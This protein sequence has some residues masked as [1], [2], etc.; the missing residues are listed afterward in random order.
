LVG[1]VQGKAVS[2]TKK[3]VFAGSA[4]ILGVPGLL[5]LCASNLETI[6]YINLLTRDANVFSRQKTD[7]QHAGDACAPSE[8]AFRL[9]E[10]VQGK[11][12]NEFYTQI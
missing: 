5:K 10:K 1:S 2:L 8:E 9:L 7:A 3:I 6:L 4:R 11:V 12:E